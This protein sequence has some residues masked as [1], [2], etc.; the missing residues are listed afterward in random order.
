MSSSVQ[1]FILPQI[2]CTEQPH[3]RSCGQAVAGGCSED[4]RAWPRSR[5][6]LTSQQ[7][8]LDLSPVMDH[9]CHSLGAVPWNLGTFSS[10]DNSLHD[11][12]TF[13]PRWFSRWRDKSCLVQIPMVL[14]W[15]RALPAPG[16]SCSHQTQDLLLLREKSLPVVQRR[17]HLPLCCSSVKNTRVRDEI[18][19]IFHFC[20]H[21][22]A[23]SFFGYFLFAFFPLLCTAFVPPA[24]QFQSQRPELQISMSSSWN[25]SQ[26]PGSYW[27]GQ[28]LARVQHC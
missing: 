19:P 16:F 6:L 11:G 21:Q 25:S 15:C 18:K 23:F 9:L 3:P 2:P 22:L 7:D 14:C 12:V 24:I 13:F 4:T 26:K 8:S 5:C 1:R 20:H 28:D 27:P 17:L 10:W